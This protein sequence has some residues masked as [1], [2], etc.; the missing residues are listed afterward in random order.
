MHNAIAIIDEAAQEDSTK[1]LQNFSKLRKSIAKKHESSAQHASAEELL[2]PETLKAFAD[3]N[4]SLLK[5]LME[6]EEHRVEQSESILEQY[7]TR[8]KELFAAA[9]E[10]IQS[11]FQSLLQLENRETEVMTTDALREAERAAN[12]SAPAAPT[13]NTGSTNTGTL[14]ITS[15][16]SPMSAEE[17]AVLSDRPS[18][19]QSLKNSTDYRQAKIH[20]NV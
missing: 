14:G 17:R 13:A 20:E 10:R 15:E 7:S 1:L 8:L 3:A 4:E 11:V 5:E 16:L 18:L 12:A 2:T 6:I 19:Q 9:K